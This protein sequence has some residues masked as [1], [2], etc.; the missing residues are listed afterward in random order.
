[1]HI[2]IPSAN[3]AEATAF[4]KRMTKANICQCKFGSVFTGSDGAQLKRELLF[5]KKFFFSTNIM[6]LILTPRIAVDTTAEL[7]I[8]SVCVCVCVCVPN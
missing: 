4:V 8:L 5:K 1:M 7:A 2:S 3:I 6:K